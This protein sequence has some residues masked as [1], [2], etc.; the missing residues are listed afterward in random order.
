MSHHA[1]IEID[2]SDLAETRL[3]E[4]SFA[5]LEEGEV[6]LAIDGFALTANNVTYAMMGNQMQYW[7]FFPAVEE[8][9]GIV[10]VW[11]HATVT[12]SECPEIQP[13]ERVYGYLPMASHLVVIP[14]QISPGGFVDMAEHRQPMAAIYSQY[15]RLAADPA[16]NPD[17]ENERAI[18]EPLFITSFLLEDFFRRNQWFEADRLALTSASSKTA[19]ALAHVARA[20]SPDVE[21][22]GL[23]SAGNVAFVIATGLYDTVLSYD[24]LETLDPALRS[25]SVDFAG[26][27]EVLRRIH[28]HFADNLGHSALVGATHVEARGGA[29]GLAGPQPVLFFAPTAARDLLAEL[30]PA[31]F[32]AAVAARWSPFV[33]D[34]AEQINVESIEGAEAVQAAWREAV[35]GGVAPDRGLI[36]TL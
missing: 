32:G 20:G 29:A 9:W 11:G 1:Q 26:N 33:A 14:G 8:D 28:A 16:H 34:I 25:V 7:N 13:G 27:G 21:R 10:P 31:G 12:E 24:E 15:R 19:L 5:P 4:E 22:V 30:G 3:V 6:R 18:F 2:K 36:C 35:A 17:Y 23:T